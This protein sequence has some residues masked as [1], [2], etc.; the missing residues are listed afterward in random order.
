M[1]QLRRAIFQR[2]GVADTREKAEG[3]FTNDVNP[4]DVAD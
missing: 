2:R 3:E 1:S 4:P